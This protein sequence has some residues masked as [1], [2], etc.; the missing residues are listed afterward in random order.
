[1]LV[2]GLCAAVGEETIGGRTVVEAEHAEIFLKTRNVSGF[3][4]WPMKEL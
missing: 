4:Q 3:A 1:V 2:A